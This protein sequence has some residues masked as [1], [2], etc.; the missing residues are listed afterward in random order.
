M[1]I[2]P[3]ATAGF[4]L[5]SAAALDSGAPSAKISTAAFVTG[6]PLARIST[7]PLDNTPPKLLFD[8]GAP[9]YYNA[10][11]SGTAAGKYLATAAGPLH[12]RPGTIHQHNP[13]RY[14]VSH[15]DGSVRSRKD[16]NK[17]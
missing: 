1:P 12:P 17:K 11:L 3:T 2:L 8:S 4:R 7:A 14:H 5:H 15:R 6:T 16:T 10:A 9:L 13:L